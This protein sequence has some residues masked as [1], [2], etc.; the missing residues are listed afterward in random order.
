M[1]KFKLSH[2]ALGLMVLSAAGCSTTRDSS[3]ALSA[4]NDENR[5]LQ[6]KLAAKE[7]SLLKKDQL[8]ASYKDRLA[9]SKASPAAAHAT[10]SA[11]PLLPTNAIAG[12]CYARVWVPAKYRTVTNVMLVKEASERVEII[13][14]E[15]RWDEEQVLVKEAS[16]KLETIP[17][18]YGIE[19]EVVVVQEAAR[20]WKTGL[21]KSSSPASGEL[22]A[23][24]KTY[25]I[26]LDSAKS[27]ECFHEHYHP[28]QYGTEA[29]R[30]KVS[31][32]T[33]TLAAAPAEY[34][35]V[36]KQV[37]V[38]EATFTL[39]DIPAEYE[40]QEEDVVDKPAH[41]TWK[42]G[43]GPIQ[44]IDETTGEIMCL[45]EIPATYK[46][47]RKRVLKTAAHTEVTEI[48]AQYKTVKIRELAVAAKEIKTEIPAKFKSV[49]I[50]KK[51][52]DPEFIWHEIHNLD[53]PTH[54][55]TG[56]KICLTTIPEITKTVKRKVVKTPATTRVIEIPAEYASMKV[57]KVIRK[58]EE[59]RIKVPSEYENVAVNELAKEGFME[60]RTILCDTNM[61]VNRISS[62]QTALQEAGYDPGPIDGDIGQLT[63]SAV[64]DFQ[65]DKNLPV[66]KYLNIATLKALGITTK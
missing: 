56:T 30:V 38:K 43:S 23:T 44:R 57:R 48:P 3:S 46:T 29:K 64:N 19:E 40:W 34:R 7:A 24:A 12:E 9:I 10:A 31:D 16:G 50:T 62:I 54:T 55:R 18:V 52:S 2:L 59:K 61:T 13:P 42:K 53:E 45:V 51:L 41:T 58:P 27:G 33:I 6:S 47:I 39:K 28:A 11:S 49:E 36:T 1:K 4:K 17:A 8:I 14:G 37:L 15:Y 22:L 21:K 32:A 35:N 26:D 63:M 5:A 65:R 25:G 20:I 66:D 60:W